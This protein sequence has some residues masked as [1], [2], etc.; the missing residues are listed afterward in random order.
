MGNRVLYQP[1][2]AGRGSEVFARGERGGCGSAG[3]SALR[4]RPGCEVSKAT[5]VRGN[6]RIGAAGRLLV[7]GVMGMLRRIGTNEYFL[8]GI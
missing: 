7:M 2:A 6:R 5:G 1:D 8:A 3:G 4:L